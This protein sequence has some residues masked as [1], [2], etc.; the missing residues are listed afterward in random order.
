MSRIDGRRRDAFSPVEHDG[1]DVGR[2]GRNA[3]HRLVQGKTDRP[4]R[5]Q[6]DPNS[7]ERPGS[8]SDRYSF[9]IGNS[10][11]RGGHAIDQRHERLIMAPVEPNGLARQNFVGR[12]V[13]YADGRRAER[14]VDRENLHRAI[15]T[16]DDPSINDGRKSDL[17]D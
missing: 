3:Y 14:R 15:V 16:F 5:G 12:A 2:Q 7:G 11:A 10:T 8:Y 6:A 17:L 13:K 9:N 4:R 1:G